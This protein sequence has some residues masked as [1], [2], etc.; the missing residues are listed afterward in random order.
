MSAPRATLDDR[1]QIEKA[2]PDWD[3]GDPLPTPG[4][5]GRWLRDMERIVCPGSGLLVLGFDPSAAIPI[6]RISRC[7]RLWFI[8]KP[9][10][11]SIFAIRCEPRNGQAV[12]RASSR[13]IIKRS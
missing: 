6:L 11:L 13:R 9:S 2:A 3:A 1:H 12:N 7:T 8:A 4:S 5:P 10:F